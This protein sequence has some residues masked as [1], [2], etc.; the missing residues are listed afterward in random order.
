MTNKKN[1]KP[2]TLSLERNE[3]SH[4]VAEIPP[5]SYVKRNSVHNLWAPIMLNT[6]RQKLHSARGL[7]RSK[8]SL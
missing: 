8:P 7:L 4:I 6:A 1:Q 5:L 3:G 2:A